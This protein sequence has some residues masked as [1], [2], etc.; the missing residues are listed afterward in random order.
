MH[1]GAGE[2]TTHFACIGSAF[3]GGAA[4]HGG[5]C[6]GNGVPTLAACDSDWKVN[7]LIVA[8]TVLGIGGCSDFNC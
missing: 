3:G 8:G 6:D 5:E 7:S 4:Y 2:A 1:C